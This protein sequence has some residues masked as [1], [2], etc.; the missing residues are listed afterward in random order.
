MGHLNSF[1]GCIG[2]IKFCFKASFAFLLTDF[3][4]EGD[5]LFHFKYFLCMFTDYSVNYKLIIKFLYIRK[6]MLP[7]WSYCHQDMVIGTQ[8]NRGNLKFIGMYYVFYI[9]SKAI[10]VFTSVSHHF[11]MMS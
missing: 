8:G 5:S 9:F 7:G 2:N 4:K 11:M 3:Q 6:G 1:V 10:A